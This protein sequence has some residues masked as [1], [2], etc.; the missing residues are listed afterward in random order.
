MTH[1]AIVE[2]LNQFADRA[3]QLGQREEPPMSQPAQH[4]RCTN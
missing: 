3:V 4:Q 1:R 2:R